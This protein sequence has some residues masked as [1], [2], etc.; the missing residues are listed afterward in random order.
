M[1][2]KNPA[3]AAALAVLLLVVYTTGLVVVLQQ[4]PIAHA[5]LSPIGI[6]AGSA[7]N[8][9]ASTS[10]DV[11]PLGPWSQFADSAS[12]TDITGLVTAHSVAGDICI[13]STSNDSSD[14]VLFDGGTP[15]AGAAMQ[16]GASTRTL[17]N[18]LDMIGLFY[19]GTVWRELFFV[20]NGS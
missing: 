12:S 13:L 10:G 16:L 3:W 17:D 6:A 2:S 20:S 9:A 14:I 1:K 11:T 4:G 8:M 5:A 15:S 7:R 18:S 19:D